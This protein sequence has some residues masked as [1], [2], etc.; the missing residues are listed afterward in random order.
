MDTGLPFWITAEPGGAAALAAALT[1]KAGPLT[2]RSV[3]VLSGGN[4]DPL[5]YAEIIAGQARAAAR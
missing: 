1:G 5:V 3:V 4:V 2:E